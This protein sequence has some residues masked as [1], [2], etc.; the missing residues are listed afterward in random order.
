MCD[1]RVYAANEL[2]RVLRVWK[3]INELDAYIDEHKE[4]LVKESTS[5]VSYLLKLKH[6]ARSSVHR[7]TSTPY[8]VYSPRG[9][10]L[11]RRLY[12]E[13]QL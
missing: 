1:T 5:A 2:K 8:T 3:Y 10:F 4:Q 13:L 7:A 11:M 6:F 12:K 9:I